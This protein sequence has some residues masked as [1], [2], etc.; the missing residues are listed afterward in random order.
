M[1]LRTVFLPMSITAGCLLSAC[2][3][4]TERVTAPTSVESSSP[5]VDRGQIPPGSPSVPP[6]SGDCV[7]AKA[8]WAIGEPASN[9][10]LERARLAAEAGSA[11][12][13]RPNQP[14]T[15]EY[16]SSR[17]NLELNEN[18]VVRAVRCG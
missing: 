11:R 14:I 7:A 10:I 17:L 12:F 13:L 9:E 4:V 3:P 6:L 15:M 1:R 18:D 2:G 16:S 8:Q 5:P